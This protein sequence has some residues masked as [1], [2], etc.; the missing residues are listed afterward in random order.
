MSSSSK[1]RERAFLYKEEYF[2][3]KFLFVVIELTL[4]VLKLMRGLLLLLTSLNC[5][6]T[7]HELC[8]YV[9]V[10]VDMVWKN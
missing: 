8:R 4:S 2:K 10:S 5:N 7:L 3:C 6:D 1:P 9:K